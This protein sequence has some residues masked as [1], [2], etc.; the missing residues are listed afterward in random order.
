MTSAAAPSVA[1]RRPVRRSQRLAIGLILAI[2]CIGAVVYRP[3]FTLVVWAI[4]IGSV[5][6]FAVL[7]A[8][9]GVA[10]ELPVALLST[11]GYIILTHFGLIHHYEGVLLAATLIVALL[12]ATLRARGGSFIGGATTLLAVLYFGKLQSYFIAIRAVPHFGAPLAVYAIVNGNAALIAYSDIFS[13]VAL[14]F[15]VSLPLIFLLGG[16]PNK[17]AAEAASSAH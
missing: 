12:T 15:V 5:R 3:A 14:A 7:I 9:N 10:I 2:V 16:K 1:V 8:R 17:Q 4:A 6:E 13:Y 11:S